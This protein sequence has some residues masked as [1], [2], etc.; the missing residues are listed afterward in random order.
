MIITASNSLN[1]IRIHEPIPMFI[2]YLYLGKSQ[3]NNL[4]GLSFEQWKGEAGF[5]PLRRSPP[6]VQ[7]YGQRSPTVISRKKARPQSFG[8]T[9]Q[10]GPSHLCKG[11]M[12]GKGS[13]HQI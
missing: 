1:K 12:L 8:L 9:P 3:L 5:F 10:A 4:A 2:N 13:F 11:W 6:E 7:D